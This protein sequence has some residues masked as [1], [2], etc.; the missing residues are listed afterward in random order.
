MSGLTFNDYKES[1][2]GAGPK[3]I[4]NILYRAR[5]IGSGISFPEYVELEGMADIALDEWA[6]ARATP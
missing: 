6:K 5:E 2:K 1:F 4:E 3:L